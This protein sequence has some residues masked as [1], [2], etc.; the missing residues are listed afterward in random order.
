MSESFVSKETGSSA[1]TPPVRMCSFAP[2]HPRRPWAASAKLL[3]LSHSPVVKVPLPRHRALARLGYCRLA[4]RP[5]VSWPPDLR[6]PFAGAQGLVYAFRAPSVKAPP[7]GLAA[8]LCLPPAVW[9]RL[10]V[11][12]MTRH[13]GVGRSWEV[14]IVRGARGTVLNLATPL[15]RACARPR[16]R[17]PPLGP[18]GRPGGL[19]CGP[20]HRPSAQGARAGRVEGEGCHRAS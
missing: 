11:G 18:S 16:P 8:F 9:W 6:G 3:S 12:A 10:L 2:A 7:R 13:V 15:S 17:G 1:P 4:G 20:G 19:L 5:P 14:G